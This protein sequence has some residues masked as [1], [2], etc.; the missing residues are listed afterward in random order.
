MIL[1]EPNSGHEVV[2]YTFVFLVCTPDAQMSNESIIHVTTVTDVDLSKLAS[3]EDMKAA[4]AN[5]D[6][7][8]K[9]EEILMQWYKQIEQVG[10][11]LNH[12]LNV[13]HCR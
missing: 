12:F 4:A 10:K 3:L 2:V 11:M 5:V 7:V 8:H 9:M 13:S 6:M 1:L